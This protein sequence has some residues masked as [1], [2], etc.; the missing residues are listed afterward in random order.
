VCRLSHLCFVQPATAVGRNEMLFCRDIHV[1]RNN[2]VALD[3][4]PSLPQ[5]G[6]FRGLEPP[7]RS[8]AANSQIT[9]AV[10]LLVYV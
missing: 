7:V 4:C 9:L 1:V 5:E 8:D 6:R 2:N 10:V 3:R